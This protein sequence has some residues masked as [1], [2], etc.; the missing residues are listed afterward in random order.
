MLEIHG[1]DD[2]VQLCRR[3][4]LEAIAQKRPGWYRTTGRDGRWVLPDWRAVAEVYG[5]VHLNVAGYLAAAVTS[6]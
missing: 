6:R 2:W 4:P 1:P 5:G 3:F